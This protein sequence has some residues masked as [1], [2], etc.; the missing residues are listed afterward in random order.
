MCYVSPLSVA[1]LGASEKID[2]T[3]TFR[4]LYLRDDPYET[5]DAVFGVKDSLLVDL[6]TVTDE[7]MAAKYGVE[8]GI[9]LL[10]YD[11]VLV[12]DAEAEELRGKK[13]LEAMAAQGRKMKL[14]NGLPVPDVD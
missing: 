11:F 3:C 1:F 10:T 13:A 7:Q 4:A 12:S 6:K 2:L 14:Y 8:V 9:K 5:S